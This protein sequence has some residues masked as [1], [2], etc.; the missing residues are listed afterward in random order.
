MDAQF[1]KRSAAR[2][3]AS[4]SRIQDQRIPA[5]SLR[6]ITKKDLSQS[7]YLFSRCGVLC[8]ARGRGH[9]AHHADRHPSRVDRKQL[10][11]TQSKR[12][13]LASAAFSCP[14]A[15]FLMAA[16]VPMNSCT[17]P[18]RHE[19]ISHQP[20]DASCGRCGPDRPC[21]PPLPHGSSRIEVDDQG[22]RGFRAPHKWECLSC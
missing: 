10:S 15:E 19:R 18:R 8:C 4:Q 1:D 5:V 7:C 13:R 6:R 12:P 17:A 14:E 20:E 2:K 3:V 11:D 22:T 16:C 9:A 21:C